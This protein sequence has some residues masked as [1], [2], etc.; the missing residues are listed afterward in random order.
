MTH[1]EVSEWEN[2]K[3]KLS[4]QHDDMNKER[5]GMPE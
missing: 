2:T 1:E 5:A 4:G 3:R